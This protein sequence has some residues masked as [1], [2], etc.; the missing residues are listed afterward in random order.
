MVVL[1]QHPR[2]G[3]SCSPPRLINPYR[4]GS[5]PP[6]RREPS[7]KRWVLYAIV[8]GTFSDTKRKQ[9]GGPFRFGS[10]PNSH[11]PK[12]PRRTKT[13]TRS[14]FTTRTELTIA[15][16]FAIAA[17]LVRTPFSWK[18]QTFFLSKKGLQRSKYGGRSKNTIA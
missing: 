9:Q 3:Y 8:V 10:V 11:L 2:V 12:G 13:T 18:L 6:E 15:L 16:G 14:K 4:Q 5:R 1:W 17:H 7:A